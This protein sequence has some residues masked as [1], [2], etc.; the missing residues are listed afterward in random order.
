MRKPPL[1]SSLYIF[2]TLSSYQIML[3]TDNSFICKI[4]Q[5]LHYHGKRKEHKVVNNYSKAT[6]KH[7][8]EKGNARKLGTITWIFILIEDI[9]KAQYWIEILLLHLQDY[10]FK[11]TTYT[12]YQSFYKSQR[13]KNNF[14]IKLFSTIITSSCIFRLIGLVGFNFNI[15]DIQLDGSPHR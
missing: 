7:K 3:V 11:G 4:V 10:L 9:F 5:I 1:M 12:N 2:I 6:R 13:R 8:F 14:R 15:I